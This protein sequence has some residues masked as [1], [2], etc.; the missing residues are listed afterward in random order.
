MKKLRLIITL[1]ILITML[2]SCAISP[3]T[4][5]LE[6]LKHQYPD[7]KIKKQGDIYGIVS[8]NAIA[9]YTNY[10]LASDGGNGPVFSNLSEL[11]DDLNLLTGIIFIGEK[12]WISD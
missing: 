6:S 12:E 4:A 10:E 11:E 5:V 2:V 7:A 9:D 1:F 3:D 8:E